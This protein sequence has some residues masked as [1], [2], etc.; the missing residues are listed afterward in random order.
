MT[1]S[2]STPPPTAPP[3]PR[4]P[5]VYSATAA[6]NM[7]PATADVPT[8]VYVPN[9]DA[10]T[11]DVIDPET[12]KVIDHFPVGKVPQ[13]I[14]PSWDLKQLYVDNTV[15]DSLTPIDPA[16]G[17]PGKSIPVQDPYNLYFTPDGSKAIVVAERFKRLDFRDPNTWQLIRSIPVSHAGVDHLDFS[18]D[19]SYFLV[20]CE[21]SGWVVK[22]DVA[23]M[24][25][26]GEVEVGGQ[27]I[28]T[29]LSPDGT[30]FY[31]ANQSLPGHHDGV[32]LV[33]GA[34]MQ[35]TGF[36][37]TGKGAHGLYFS[38]DA[39]SLYVTNRLGGSVSVIDVAT[40]QVT[41]TW[42]VPRGS[43]DMGGVSADGTQFWVSGRYN[44]E[45]YVI[46]TRS[47][48]LL[49]RIPVGKGPHG[50]CIFPQP[51]RYSLGHTGNYR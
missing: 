13:H 46:D 36:I 40:G 45:V 20:S 42:T 21:F 39:K 24:E 19:G 4:P 35:K 18:A 14:T 5:D 16:S 7:A 37:P 3:A 15:G 51:G 1:P 17:K 47:G 26:V 29:R 9:S 28:D 22:V 38:R 11:V 30:T 10:A 6:G 50:L 25:I 33:D 2:T 27:P 48:E 31:V 8:R 34:S 23:T 12:F 32:T 41:A 49:A 44:G 43:P